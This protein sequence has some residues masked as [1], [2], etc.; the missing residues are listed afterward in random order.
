MF[1]NSANIPRQFLS[2]RHKPAT[3]PAH[4][5]CALAF[6][7]AVLVLDG[8]ALV[9]KPATVAPATTVTPATP[10]APTAPVAKSHAKS[11]GSDQ[12]TPPTV[13]TPGNEEQ[14][15]DRIKQALAKNHHD[16]LTPVEVGYYMDVLQGRL[17]QVA[18]KQVDIRRQGDSIVLDLSSGVDFGSDNVQTESGT[19]DILTLIS[20]VLVDYRM[21]LVSIYVSPDDSVAS[22]LSPPL[23]E[24]RALAVAKILATTDIA[25]KGAAATGVA[26]TGVAGK[27]I[28]IT[29]IAPVPAQTAD[30]SKKTSVRIEFQ[31]DPIVRVTNK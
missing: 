6:A 26:A 4:G 16:S 27:R 20:K 21:V 8:C 31:L 11:H 30:A 5:L 18:G 23:A 15:M 19:S 9:H 22:A 13:L 29:R 17:N 1:I 24:Q 14:D 7:T 10:V 3:C 28:V 25:K 12:T 2:A